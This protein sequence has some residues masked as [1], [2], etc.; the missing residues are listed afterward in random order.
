MVFTRRTIT[1]ILRFQAALLT[2]A[3]LAGCA[4]AV[5][6]AP[7]QPA[8]PGAPPA[9]APAKP[10]QPVTLKYGILGFTWANSW[11]LVA[12]QKGFF[13]D[14]KLTIESVI[15][16]PSSAG[17]CQQVLAKAAELGS[18]SINDMIQAVENG[19]T[20]LVQ[21]IGIYNA[22]INYGVMAKANI[23]AWADLKGKTVMVGGPKDNTVYFIHVMARANGLKDADYDFQYA[24]SSGNRFAAL[25]AGAVDAAIVTDPFDFQAEQEGF[26][27]LDNMV[28]KYVN[29]SNYGYSA[30]VVRADWAKDHADEMTRFIRAY[31]RSI[32]WMHDPANKDALF[33]VV[34]PKLNMTRESFERIYKGQ[35]VESKLYS[36]DGK[37]TDAGV[38]GVLKSLVELGAL[39]DPTPPPGKYYDLTWVN[40]ALQSLKR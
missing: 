13:A 33:Q 26:T 3:V 35:I 14:E 40:L 23:R 19:A 24:G 11:E 27:R 28:P 6:P 2:V 10:V 25:K 4:P 31:F 39:K 17:V 38:G 21:F 1:P 5:A 20:S 15:A 29:G 30:H 12:E 8:A 22:P 37:I 34:S 7:A 36:T 32:A 16:N 9:A 18:C